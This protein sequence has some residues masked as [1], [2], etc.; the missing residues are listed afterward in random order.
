MQTDVVI[1]AYRSAAHLRACVEP[2]A[3]A[4][5]VN[6]IV[7]DNDCPERSPQLV[8]DLPVTIVEMGRNAGFSAGC[9]AG[10]AAGSGGAL[11]FLNPDARIAPDAVRSISDVL[12]RFPDVGAVGPHVRETSGADQPTMRREPTLR[13]AFAEALFLHH[14]NGGK[15][16]W[17]NQI[18]MEGYDRPAESDWLSGAALCIRRDAFEEVQGFDERFFLYSEDTDICVRL[19]ARG[20]Q[21]RYDPVATSEHA[22]GGSAPRPG[23]AALKVQARIVYA[24]LHATGLRY[25]GFRVAFALNEAVRVP[26]AVP[27]SRLHL[28][29]RLAALRTAV[30][31]KPSK[32]RT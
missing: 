28:T 16:A 13:S 32:V 5:D 17:T 9:N 2:L 26:L 19:R 31:L 14:L 4:D 10:A 25:A 15:L 7:V 12:A 22:G 21:V 24:R 18:V 11:L 27:R 29:G 20:W 1:V 3:G 23:Q 6:V 30:R 8:A